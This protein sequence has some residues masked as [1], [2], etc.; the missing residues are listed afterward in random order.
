MLSDEERSEIEEEIRHYAR[1]RGASVEAL[2]CVQRRRGWVDDETLKEVADMLGMSVGELDGVA[3][4]YNLIFRRP[5]GKNVI[6][7]CN[8]I[9]CMVMGYENILAHL[10]ERLGIRLGQTTADGLFTLLPVP[11]LGACDRSP[12]MM[13][14]EKLYPGLT[15]E[16]ADE[17]LREHGWRG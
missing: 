14:G 13:V 1:K 5:V 6:L 8:T 17:I 12:V 10:E 4:F 16:I 7:I 15:P 9:S 11:C 3:T 2:M